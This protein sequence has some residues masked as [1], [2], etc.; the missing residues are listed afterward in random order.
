MSEQTPTQPESTQQETA[1]TTQNRENGSAQQAE[2]SATQEPRARQ[3]NASQS[4]TQQRYVEDDYGDDD[5]DDYDGEYDDYDDGGDSDEIKEIVTSGPAD[6]T[7]S[8]QRGRSRR[9]NNEVKLEDINYKKVTVLNKFLDP[10]GRILSRRKTGVSAK[11][12]RRAVAAIKRARHLALLPYTAE[13]T[14]IT[15]IHRRGSGQ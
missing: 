9:I 8:T 10:R 1:E 5:Y 7:P 12:Q 13:Q 11:V 4:H 6:Y 15:R 3:N 2:T 14:R